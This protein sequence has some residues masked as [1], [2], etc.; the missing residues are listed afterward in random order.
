M[1][2]NVDIQP[3]DPK[4]APRLKQIAVAAKGYWGYADEWM[5]RWASLLDFPL[6]YVHDNEVYVALDNG[7]IIGFYALVP[8]GDLCVLDHLWVVPER[9]GTGIGRML[10]THALGR[11]AA[12][13]AKQLEWEA[14]PHAV[15]FYQ[16]MGG[17]HVREQATE[18]EGDLPIMG[19]DLDPSLRS[20]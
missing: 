9:I 12:L 8:Y 13:G 16:R 10:F 14:D 1:E 19:M 20:R 18:L 2:D 7:E 5:A 6:A 4:L 11:A 17:R 3:A 15:G